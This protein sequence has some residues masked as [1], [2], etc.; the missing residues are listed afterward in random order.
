MSDESPS[1]RVDL[2]PPNRR[3]DSWKA[4]ADYLGR[5]VTTLQRWEHE[6]GLPV[7][8]HLHEKRGSVFAYT[9]ELDAWFVGRTVPCG[10]EGASTEAAERLDESEPDPEHRA[11]PVQAPAGSSNTASADRHAAPVNPTGGPPRDLRKA[12]GD[13]VRS[14]RRV[15]VWTMVAAAVGLTIVVAM[16]KDLW[17]A[18]AGVAPLSLAV[19]PLKNRSPDQQPDY[20]VDG[21]TE[22][23]TT[24]L[25]SIPA[26][27]VIASQ[28]VM[29]Y[30]GHRQACG[31]HR[32]RTGRRRARRGR[33]PTKRG[34]CARRYPPD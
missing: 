3:L 23:L 31:R 13:T 28:S 20:F 19:L 9:A 2:T 5:H 34:T 16:A 29:Q 11:A 33:G 24:D 1:P 4:I 17:P 8:R 14:R 7:H 18:R 26:V 21:M 10:A 30:P 27:R 12:I 22:A 25:A 15:A 6:E 32:A